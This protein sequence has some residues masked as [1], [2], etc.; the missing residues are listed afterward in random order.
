M[1]Y[2][3][4]GNY[5]SDLITF[6]KNNNEYARLDGSGRFG[7]GTSS[8]Q[9]KLDVRGASAEFHLTN[10]TG[11]SATAGTAQVV[12]SLGQK[13]GVYGPAGAITFRQYDATWSSVN[14][15][16]KPTRIEFS[17]QDN[18]A[19]D[20]SESARMVIDRDGNVGIGISSPGVNLEVSDAS[21]TSIRVRSTAT[22]SGDDT[23]LRSI[24]GGT[25]AS[26]YIFF[27]DSGSSSAGYIRYQHSND[28][29]QFRV[30]G[31][32]RLRINS[33]G[34]VGIGIVNPL[35][36]LVI[37]DAA[38]GTAINKTSMQLLRSNYG[39]QISGYI[40]PG[41]SSGMTFSTVA[42]Q[43]PTERM[44]LKSNGNVGIGTED[45]KERLDVAG[46]ILSK[47]VTYIANQDQAYL[48][49]GT[50]IYTGGGS[51]WGTYGIQHRF[52]SNSVGTARVTI[53]TNNGEAFCVNNPGNVGIGTNNP[54][55]KLQV[56]GDVIVDS[57]FIT[58]NGNKLGAIR[59][60]I[61]DDAFATITP[62]R[63]GAGHI[64]VVEGG[65][66]Q[67]PDSSCQ[68][69]VYADWGNSPGVNPISLGTAFET[70]NAGPPNGTT[71]S[72]LHATLFVG[73][74]SGVVYLENRLGGSRAFFVNFL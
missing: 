69:F 61:A 35:T 33:S 74:T 23:Y 39:G 27:G 14:Q 9:A 1:G 73:G 38:V 64:S 42:N 62:P 26:N 67:F 59:V 18:T 52:K 16:I 30:N 47:T 53:D 15:Y 4:L 63:V 54:Q 71:G 41:T 12:K 60:T 55:A 8:P 68:G 48:V 66:E 3:Q 34:N 25:T 32:E 40:I 17:T 57:G 37:S 36:K 51:S 49:A 11:I 7:I 65:D 24:V 5:N 19:T 10:T 22:G 46:T 56:A 6:G 28:S 29:L 31:S 21:N 13:N 2:I 50:T 44:R 72:D 70:S 58:L 45:P 20:S 43:V